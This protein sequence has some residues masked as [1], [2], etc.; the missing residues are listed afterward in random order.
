MENKQWRMT[1]CGW[2]CG[3]ER[4]EG[5]LPSICNGADGEAMGSDRE[6]RREMVGNERRSRKWS[7]MARDPYTY[8]VFQAGPRICLG[9][10]MAFLQMKRVVSGVLRRFS[11]VPVFEKRV[12]P[13][14]IS[15]LTSKMKGGFPV[16]IEEMAENF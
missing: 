10:E 8:L 3:Q 14:F 2:D 5:D 12:E 4:Y 15:Y 13:E 6:F 9:K 7:F 1:C 16:R 11:V